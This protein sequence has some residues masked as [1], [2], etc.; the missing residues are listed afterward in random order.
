MKRDGV[1]SDIRAFFSAAVSDNPEAVKNWR[2]GVSGSLLAFV[3]IFA[4][5]L[6]AFSKL[7][8]TG[9]ALASDLEDVEKVVDEK[10][11][12]AVSP[13]KAQLTTHDGYL[14]RL[15]KKDIREELYE[16]FVKL[17]ESEGGPEKQHLRDEIEELQTE[18]EDVN[19]SKYPQPK[20]ED[21]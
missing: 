18:Y 17:C 13:I 3:L 15:V 14:K 11:T 19:D 2:L 21:L 6:G 12:A 8:A 4:W 20:C 1:I 10:I 16:K 7:G 9:V 5:A